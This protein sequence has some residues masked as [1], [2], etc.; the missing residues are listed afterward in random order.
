M[1]GHLESVL[2]TEHGK[3][4]VERGA[5][6]KPTATDEVSSTYGVFATELDKLVG[7]RATSSGPPG[8]EPS[9]QEVDSSD[10]VL[11]TGLGKLVVEVTAGGEPAKEYGV[12]AALAKQ[13]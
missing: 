4:V 13:A 6:S 10:G 12:L 9:E 8:S 7:E 11:A 5:G 3:L 1:G 2:A